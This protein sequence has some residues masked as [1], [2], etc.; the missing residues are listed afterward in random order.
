MHTP[1]YVY[2]FIPPWNLCCSYLLVI[3]NTA[4]MNM[5]L[6]DLASSSLGHTPK[7]GIAGSYISSNFICKEICAIFH[8]SCTNFIPTKGVQCYCSTSSPALVITCFLII[9]SL[10]D[11]RWYLVAVLVCTSPMISDV[12][13]L[14]MY[15]LAIY[16]FGKMTIQVLCLFLTG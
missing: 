4:T 10:I 1:H 15:P 6:Q 7:S 13:H 2:S 14:S 12:Q 9:A 11:V 5:G 16:F 8:S 3:M